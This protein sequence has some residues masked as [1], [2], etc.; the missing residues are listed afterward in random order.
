MDLLSDMRLFSRIVATGSLSAAGRE[1]GLSP[2]AVSQRLKSLEERYSAPLLTRSSRAI[3]LTDEGRTFLQAAH[4]VISE[5]DALD[6]AL[7]TKSH[8]LVGRLRVAAPCDLGRQ[9][10]EPLILEFGDANPGL[11]VELVLS[12]ALDD[13]IGK[14][15]DVV[16]RYGNLSDSSLVGRSIAANR[17]VLVASPAYLEAHGTPSTPDDLVRH[18]CLVLLRGLERL[19]RWR[20]VIDGNET[21][22]SVHAALAVNDGELLR[23]WALAGRGIAMKSVL[24]VKDDLENG[25]LVELLTA[26]MPER[27]GVQILF[28]AARRETP[29]VRAFVDAV[30]CRCAHLFE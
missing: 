8:G 16:I 21:V 22:Q 13:V 14:D 24:D 9:V 18:R 23:H 27:V 20:F 2:G 30:V 4:S 1:L 6:M 17:R 3:A 5:A 19:D 29:R 10:I 11:C 25:R 28:S 12:D 15:F 7:R 26:F